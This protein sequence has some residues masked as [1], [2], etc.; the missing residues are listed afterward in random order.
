[1]EGSYQGRFCGICDHELGCGYFSLS[2]RSLSV[3]GNEPG[4]VLVSDD[5][6]LTDFCGQECADYAEA[7]IS[8]TLTSPYPTAAKTVPCSLC[9]RPVDRKEPHVSVSMTRFED[10]SQPWPVSAR[11]VDER[12]L[13]VYCSGCAEPRRASSFD[14]SE[15]GVA[16]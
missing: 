5:N 15:L 10:D 4:V 13:A 3:T 6:L 16:V 12:E 8:S 11:V 1:M 2:K 9:L 14:E 7:A